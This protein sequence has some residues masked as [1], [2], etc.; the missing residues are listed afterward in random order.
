MEAE[1]Q[2][3]TIYHNILESPFFIVEVEV[4]ERPVIM[5]D[6]N[7]RDMKWLRISKR[8][9]AG[10][11]RPGIMMNMMLETDSAADAMDN[12]AEAFKEAAEAIRRD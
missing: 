1:V 11:G 10:F 9:V 8:P 7:T 6:D 3:R 2:E 4:Y 5:L 12:M